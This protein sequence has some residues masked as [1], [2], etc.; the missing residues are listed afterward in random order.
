MLSLGARNKEFSS[1][2]ARSCCLGRYAGRYP[3][4]TSNTNAARHVPRVI[5]ESSRAVL[6]E[7][8][9]W[10][11]RAQ[12]LYWVDIERG[13]LH[14]CQ[15]DGSNETSLQIGARIGCIAL[16]RDSA[17]FI[18]GLERSIVL[19]TLN[20]L[21]IRQVALLD[22]NL[23]NNRCND[24]KCDAEGRFWVGT[25]DTRW[26]H[27]TG[28]IYRLDAGGVPVRTAGPFICTNGPAMSPDGRAI[29]CVDSFGQIVYQSDIVSSG[30][31]SG[32]RVFRKF[33]AP[34]WGY[35]DG[36]TCDVEGG[37]WVAHWGAS[38]V[39]RFSPQGDL[40]DVIQL[41]VAQP[42]SCTFGGSDLR[43]LFITTASLG[44]DAVAN[45]NG[46]AGA[47]FAVDLDI[48]G[49]PAARFAG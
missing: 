26:T 45:A 33:D 13:E 17:G 6:G 19:I 38:R 2:G 44:L 22:E 24:G 5:T 16:R 47:V 35:P 20:P 12:T 28:W 42:T 25:C 15:A 3:V 31:L 8:P 1:D 41:P 34:G 27:A 37:V 46:L 43:R 29:Y 39:S 18:A 49:L 36:L 14:H 4:G 32:Q 30:E 23:P 11:E 9:V 10:D 48:G 40:L 21:E 7:S